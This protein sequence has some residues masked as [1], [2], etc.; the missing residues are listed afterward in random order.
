M[1]KARGRRQVDTTRPRD[2]DRW[3]RASLATY[4][5]A[6]TGVCRMSAAEPSDAIAADSTRGRSPGN[7]PFQALPG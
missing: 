1:A 7:L 4:I 3:R 5:Q 2:A 6:G